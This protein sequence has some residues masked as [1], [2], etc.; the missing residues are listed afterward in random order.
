MNKEYLD[1]CKECRTKGYNCAQ[2]VA[3][4]FIDRLPLD[5]KTVFKAMEGFGG[6]MGGADGTCGAISG[7]VMVISLLSSNGDC[8]NTSKHSTYAIVKELFDSFVK[9]NGSSVCKELQGLET[10]IALRSCDACIEDA[11]LITQDLLR[12]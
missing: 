2:A 12:L 3:C 7:A 10:K 11:V 6:G 5:E 8:Q 9:K 4:A 1:R